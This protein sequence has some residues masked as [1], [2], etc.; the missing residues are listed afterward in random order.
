MPP[1]ESSK[2]ALVF[3]CVGGL[4]DEPLDHVLGFFPD[5]HSQDSEKKFEVEHQIDLKIY[6]VKAKA[7]S[8]EKEFKNILAGSVNN[9]L[10]ENGRK[11]PPPSKMTGR[12]F[13]A[14]SVAEPYFHSACQRIR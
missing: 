2:K 4:A 8:K 12:W 14:K 10:G 5:A 9:R 6:K 1:A 13:T 3:C 11:Q 7:L